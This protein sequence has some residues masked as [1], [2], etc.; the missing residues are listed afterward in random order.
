MR[1]WCK[2]LKNSLG[3]T[4]FLGLLATSKQESEKPP[5]KRGGELMDSFGNPGILM[6]Q[7]YRICH[8]LCVYIYIQIQF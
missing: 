4:P 2:A 8:I 5:K 3:P 7:M 1:W 6:Q